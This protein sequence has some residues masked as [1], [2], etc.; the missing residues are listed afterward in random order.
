MEEVGVNRRAHTYRHVAAY[1]E[2][3]RSYQQRPPFLSIAD[4]LIAEEED[5]QR[6]GGELE[7][8]DYGVEGSE[9]VEETGVGSDLD[10]IIG[11]IGGET[12]LRLEVLRSLTN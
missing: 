5:G 2:H 12:V 4:G 3:Q 11:P 9:R 8:S 6:A 10:G 1:A 7:D